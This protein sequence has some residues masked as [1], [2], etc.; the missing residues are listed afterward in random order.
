MRINNKNNLE[1]YTSEKLLEIPFI[2]HFF[3]ARTEHNTAIMR[4]ELQNRDEKGILYRLMKSAGFEGGNALGC[5]LKQVHGDWILHV[6]ENNCSS[7]IGKEGDA[8]ITTCSSL[9]I[10]VF[11]A[12]CVPILLSDRK[13]SVIAAVHAGWRGTEQQI[14][15]KTALMMQEKYGCD[16]MDIICAIGPHIGVCCFEVSREIFDCFEHKIMKESRYY[17]DLSAENRFQLMKA[18]IPA[19][20]ID[21]QQYCTRCSPNLHSFRRE[22]EVE[23]RQVSMIQIIP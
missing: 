9:A 6:D 23:G 3:S 4:D 11:T 8:M 12:D 1:F 18:G 7:M 15:Y 13:K 10:G 2:R 20:H 19:D 21:N 14:V 5:C 22:P 17:V 16:A